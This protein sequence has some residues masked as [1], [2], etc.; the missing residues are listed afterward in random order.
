MNRRELIKAAIATVFVPTALLDLG[1]ER[2]WVG[3]VSSPPPAPPWHNLADGL[4]ST[5]WQGKVS[6]QSSKTAQGPWAMTREFPQNEQPRPLGR[7][8]SRY[9]QC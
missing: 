3:K 2:P 6:I 1:R 5:V 4:Q 8:G 7:I 9:V